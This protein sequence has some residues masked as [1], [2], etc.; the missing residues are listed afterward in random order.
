MRTTKPTWVKFGPQL[1]ELNAV[2]AL[3]KSM[4]IT[5]VEAGGYIALVV[6]YAIANADDD[7]NIDHL[8]DKS[9]ETAC[10]WTGERGELVRA[11]TENGV[12]SGERDSDLQPLS[13]EPELWRTVAGKTI[14][15]RRAARKRKA[16]E[17]ANKS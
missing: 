10:Y 17:R 12:F 1:L 13:I 4:S 15:E 16:K 9:I 3:A 11:F 6:A 7:G 5:Q 14:D 8:T 2:S